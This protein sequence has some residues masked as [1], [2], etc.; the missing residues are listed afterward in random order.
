MKLK[1]KRLPT[2]REIPEE[3]IQSKIYLL[4]GRK[5]M[6]DSDLAILYEVST[7]ALI[8]AVKRNMERFPDDF[9]Q[10]MTAQEVKGLISQNVISKTGRGGRRTPPL[11]FTEQGVAMLSSVL[12][13][14]RAIQVNIQIMRIFTKIRLMFTDT[15]SLK[16]D[17]EGIKKKLQ[18]QDKNIELVFSYLDELITKQENKTPHKRIG[19][20]AKE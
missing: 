3:A 10:R 20:K 7:G 11:V 17:I 16:L 8:Q 18:N 12:K 1:S 19:Y 4:R 9:M 5:V 14:G 13:S 6:M 2:R 15:L